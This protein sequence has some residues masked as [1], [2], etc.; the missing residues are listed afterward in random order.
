MVYEIKLDD[1][2]LYFPGSWTLSQAFDWMNA[3]GF[4]LMLLEEVFHKEH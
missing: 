3:R 2:T 4:E 1:L